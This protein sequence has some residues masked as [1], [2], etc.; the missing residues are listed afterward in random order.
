MRV[1]KLGPILLAVLLT[2]ACSGLSS[3]GA[4]SV[5]APVLGQY[6]TEQIARGVLD[7][8]STFLRASQG[9][10]PE[11]SA[12]RPTAT[13]GV[14]PAIHKAIDVNN[15]IADGINTYCNGSPLLSDDPATPHDET[16]PYAQGGPCSPVL[17]AKPSLNGVMSEAL[18]I[19][20]QYAG[21]KI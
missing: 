6:T 13:Q 14:C 20:S 17:G 12:N 4:K 7:Q 16:R 5:R 2:A 15:R 19:L 21:G 1:L 9:N 8:L 3:C 11:C 10:H 18:Y